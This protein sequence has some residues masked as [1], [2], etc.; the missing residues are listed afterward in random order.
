MST[1]VLVNKLPSLS[2]DPLIHG[3]FNFSNN[4]SVSPI[5][6]I[7]IDTQR[8]GY[9]DSVDLHGMTNYGSLEDPSTPIDLT[10]DM[11]TLSPLIGGNP[12]DLMGHMG[13]PPPMELTD[14]GGSLTVD[15]ELPTP[16]MEP[17][18]IL[19]GGNPLDLTE[20][21]VSTD[22][23]TDTSFDLIGGNLV[24]L[25][26]HMV[27]AD[28]SVD[29]SVD[30]SFDLMGGNLV[31][32]T[33]HMVSTDTPVDTSVYTPVDTP[34]DLMGGSMDSTPLDLTKG[35]DNNP[36]TE[37]TNNYTSVSLQQDT[38]ALQPMDTP[39][40]HTIA[41]TLDNYI[42][43]M[44][45]GGK[46]QKYKEFEY[47][48]NITDDYTK[49]LDKYTI[50]HNEQNSKVNLKKYKYAVDKGHLT[51]TNSKNTKLIDIQQPNYIDIK[52]LNMTLKIDMDALLFEMKMLR[53][54]ILISRNLKKLEAFNKLKKEY[55]ALLDVKDKVSHY[56]NEVNNIN[57][58]DFLLKS[59]INNKIESKLKLEVLLSEIK[60]ANIRKESVRDKCIEYIESN[61]IHH[62][63]SQI[64]SLQ[65]TPP[66]NSI[67]T[68]TDDKNIE[69]ESSDIPNE[70]NDLNES[71]L[72]IETL[73]ID[74]DDLAQL[75]P[76][77]DPEEISFYENKPEVNPE[78]LN[79]P[80]SPTVN[81]K[82]KNKKSLK[83]AL[84]KPATKKTPKK[85][86]LKI[87]KGT[88]SIPA[89]TELHKSSL[90][91]S[92]FSK[93]GKKHRTSAGVPTKDGKCVF[94]F[95]N[96]KKYITKEDGCIGSKTGDWCATEVDKNDDYKIK[97]FGYCK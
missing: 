38:T 45:A 12:I 71:F 25:T 92:V 53:N 79:I 44:T 7:V 65:D 52:K 84:L 17:S 48:A 36:N 11:G 59:L 14:I 10:G 23:P 51:K 1:H 89:G 62:I 95:K 82:T 28:T 41:T 16:T 54:E 73:N 86:K 21:M 66:I 77:D 88:N 70:S 78:D 6:N 26:E 96:G 42:T 2:T 57:E 69:D 74:N 63:D 43:S 49:Y 80:L 47:T 3:N 15:T 93:D 33:E 9:N 37:L 50:F 32:L 35:I 97:A 81:D 40:S 30:T 87:I 72:N 76:E 46:K 31:D 19:I 91:A 34:V 58:K 13:S 61:K 18:D 60:Q 8:A 4:T 55:I 94:P 22:T 5:K 20:H 56:Y 27:A 68:Y 39:N 24:D 29:T 83:K 67:I 64:R 75:Q 90:E 85:R